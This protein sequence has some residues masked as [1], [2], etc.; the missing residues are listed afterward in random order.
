MP[1]CAGHFPLWDFPALSDFMENCYEILGVPP[2]ASAAEIRRAFRKKA[3]SLHP[4]TSKDFKSNRDFH[5]LVQAYEILSDAKQR[6]L[7]DDSLPGFRPAAPK[8]KKT[9]DYH[10]WLLARQDDESR[11]RLIFWD[12]LHLREDEAVEEFKRLSHSNSRFSLRHWFSRE[13]FMDCGFILAEEL[14]LRQ[15]Y[16]H[17]LS[18][19]AEIIA[20]EREINYFRLFFPEVLEFTLG[21]LKNNVEGTGNDELALDLWGRALELGFPAKENAFFLRKMAETYLKFGDTRTAQLCLA[22]AER[23]LRK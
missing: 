10:E 1:F 12:L 19:L 17:A 6:A 18:L 5:R 8:S 2:D 13:E 14:V 3:K 21:I 15:E 4:D 11:A 22:E 23:E 9:F 7:L 16:G 20:L